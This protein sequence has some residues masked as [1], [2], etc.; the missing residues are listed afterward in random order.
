MLKR[1]FSIVLTGFVL[2]GFVG[3]SKEKKEPVANEYVSAPGQFAIVFPDGF[4]T[5]KQDKK[6]IPTEFGSFDLNIIGAENPQGA[7]MVMY[8]DFPKEVFEKKTPKQILDDGRDNALKTVNGT[9]SKE[10]ETTFEGAIRRSI[11]ISANAGGKNVHARFDLMIIQNRLY[12]I[13][14]LAL[15]PEDLEKP[16]VKNYFSSFKLKK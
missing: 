15:L 9:L 13:A 3:C 1:F 12:Q 6:N 14:Y 2:V 11:Y 8:S 5:P 16:E 10:E 4:G 7:A